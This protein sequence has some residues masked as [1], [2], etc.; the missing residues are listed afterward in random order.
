MRNVFATII[1]I[2]LLL[3]LLSL[4]YNNNHHHLTTSAI[5]FLIKYHHQCRCCFDRSPPICFLQQGNLF[6]IITDDGNNLN[7]LIECN[8]FFACLYYYIGCSRKIIVESRM[9]MKIDVEM[10]IKYDTSDYKIKL[11]ITL[12][13]RRAP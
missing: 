5:I 6:A 2:A 9:V 7:N 4:L 3:L 8:K 12:R 11:K 1:I 10:V 13:K